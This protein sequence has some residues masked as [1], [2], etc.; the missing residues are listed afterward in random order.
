LSYLPDKVEGSGKIMVPFAYD[1]VMAA[2]IKTINRH[3]WHA[4]EKHLSFPNY[5][6]YGVLYTP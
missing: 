6:R 2:K 3:K 4:V 1:P 5:V